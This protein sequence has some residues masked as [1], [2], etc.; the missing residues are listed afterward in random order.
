MPEVTREKFDPESVGVYMRFAPLD[1]SGKVY[2]SQ[3]V[4]QAEG[5]IFSVMF[6]FT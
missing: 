2:F 1:L 5:E 6:A 3:P 4:E